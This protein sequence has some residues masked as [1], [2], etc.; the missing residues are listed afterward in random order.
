M[1]QQESKKIF[2]VGLAF[3]FS[4]SFALMPIGALAA[5]IYFGSNSKEVGAGEKFEIGVFIDTKEESINAIESNIDFPSDFL[6]FQGIEN[7]S[8]I[9]NLWV[10]QPYVLSDGK[11]FFSGV[12][13]GGFQGN[14][15]YLFSI[16]FKAKNLLS[17]SAKASI[18]SSGEK[19]LLNDGSGSRADITKAPLSL[20]IKQEVSPEDFAPIYDPDPPEPFLLQIARDENIFSNRWFLVFNTQDKGSGIDY[21]E[22]LEKP[23]PDSIFSLFKKD[24]WAKG[25]SPYLLTDQSLQ[26]VISVKAVDRVSNSRIESLSAF[27]SLSWYE[28]FWIWIIITIIMAIILI[29]YGL[30]WKFHKK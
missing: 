2:S 28:N 18:V 23:Q 9:L 12:V 16:I 3:L 17:G 10:K 1:I 6:E 20:T 14:K 5:E 7:G 11:V 24:E 15:G 30:W 27:H 29:S 21:Y 25:Q 13:P 4:V 19:I 8:S 26:S 22:I